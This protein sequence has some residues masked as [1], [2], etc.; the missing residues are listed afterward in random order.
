MPWLYQKYAGH[1]NNRDWFMLN[2]KETRILTDLMYHEWHPTISYDIHQMGNRG[3]RFFV[4]PFFDPVNPNVDPLIHQSL[5]L[6]GGHMATALQEQGKTGV[7]Y[8][9]IFDNWWQ[10]G[11]RTTPYRHNIVGILTEAASVNMASPIFQEY[12]DLRGRGR[13]FRKYEPAVNFPEPWRGG[14]WRLRDIVDYEKIACRALFTLAARYRDRFV[15]NHLSLGEN[16]SRAVCLDQKS[17][18]TRKNLPEGHC[19]PNHGGPS[20]W[21]AC[22]PCLRRSRG[23]RGREYPRN[24][25]GYA[26]L[27]THRLAR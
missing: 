15:Q 18:R 2:L 21:K 16:L 7:V 22:C 8:K 1:D 5:L 4:P 17:R 12:R 13:G 11:N 19:S 6:I 3:A 26:M 14:W 25:P 24:Q 9:A 27:P 10:G 23:R 20:Q